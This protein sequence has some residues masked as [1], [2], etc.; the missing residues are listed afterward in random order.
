[1]CEGE[2]NRELIEKEDGLEYL[3]ELLK[4]STDEDLKAE[5]VG[6]IGALITTRIFLHTRT[7]SFILTQKKCLQLCSCESINPIQSNPIQ[8]NQIKENKVIESEELLL[9]LSYI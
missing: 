6:A 8:S 7:L 2:K 1:V 5:C 4:N 3:I 9:M